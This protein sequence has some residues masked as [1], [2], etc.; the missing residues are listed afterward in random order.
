LARQGR[1]ATVADNLQV[2]ETKLGGDLADDRF[3]ICFN[4]EAAE[5]DRSVRER[6]VAVL[7]ERSPA[8]TSSAPRNAPNCAK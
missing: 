5:R 8:P 6:L 3:I 7:T 4:P 2:K 1:Y